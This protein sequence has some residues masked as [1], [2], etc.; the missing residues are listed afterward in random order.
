KYSEILNR[1]FEWIKAVVNNSNTN[2]DIRSSPPNTTEANSQGILSFEFMLPREALEEIYSLKVNEIDYFI[3][4]NLDKQLFVD[5]LTSN[6]L[7]IH[8]RSIAFGCDIQYASLTLKALQYFLKTAKNSLFA[9]SKV[10][11]TKDGTSLTYGHYR[12]AI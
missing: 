3:G 2:F 12:K 1:F 5:I 10:F 8:Q 7:S 4:Q 9:D 11:L 6:D